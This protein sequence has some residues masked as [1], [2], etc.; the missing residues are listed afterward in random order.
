MAYSS[1][2][3]QR[4]RSKRR[5]AAITF[6]S[7]ISLDGTHFHTSPVPLSISRGSEKENDCQES[8]AVQKQLLNHT[9]STHHIEQFEPSDQDLG[10]RKWTDDV[11]KANRD[12]HNTQSPSPKKEDGSKRTSTVSQNQNVT[13]LLRSPKIV[14]QERFQEHS[15]SGKRWRWVNLVFRATLKMSMR[16]TDIKL[17]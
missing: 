2:K 12:L 16:S 5:L 13:A 10:R 4:Q 1:R 7:N 8:E 9:T 14:R 11:G 3:Q 6:L 17:I 15:H